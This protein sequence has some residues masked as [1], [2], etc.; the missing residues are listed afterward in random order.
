MDD[1]FMPKWMWIG[2]AV[3][4]PLLPPTPHPNSIQRS[5]RE[6][7]I[8]GNHRSLTRFNF[9][10]RKREYVPGMII[11]HLFTFREVEWWPHMTGGR[12]SQDADDERVAT[13]DDLH[14]ILGNKQHWA[15][16]LDEPEPDGQ[17][18]FLYSC[19]CGER[20]SWSNTRGQ[21]DISTDKCHSGS[22]S[23]GTVILS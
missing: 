13:A 3:S 23:A 11:F 22:A 21:H 1:I 9:L 18:R 17:R 19:S 8:A 4:S 2:W 15:R 14:W 16:Q 10:K 5:R 20:K 12:S 6:K 7:W